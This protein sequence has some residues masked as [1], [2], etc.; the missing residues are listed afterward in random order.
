MAAPIVFYSGDES[1]TGW[2]DRMHRSRVAHGPREGPVA[3][4]V[5]REAVGIEE[6]QGGGHELDASDRNVAHGTGLRP[7]NCDELCKATVMLQWGQGHGRRR[8]D[9]ARVA[10]ELEAA[11]RRHLAHVRLRFVATKMASDGGAPVPL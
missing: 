1:H 11:A 7:L 6:C 3:P 10:G 8:E 4:T 5:G 2:M 9:E